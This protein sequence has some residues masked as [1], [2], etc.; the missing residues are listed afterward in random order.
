MITYFNSDEQFGET[1]I[2]G[3]P[4]KKNNPIGKIHYL[5]YCERFL[6]QI[7]TFQR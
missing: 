6:H 1:N 7:Y 4:I 2:E 5:C 3:A